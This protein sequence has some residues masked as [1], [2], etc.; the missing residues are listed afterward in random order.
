MKKDA[1]YFMLILLLAGGAFL[2]GRHTVEK[3]VQEIIKTDTLTV[4][5]LLSVM[6]ALYTSRKMLSSLY[7]FQSETR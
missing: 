2:V 5:V 4:Y 3:Q 6:T 7:M 1:V